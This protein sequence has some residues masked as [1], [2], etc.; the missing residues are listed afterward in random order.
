MTQTATILPFVPRPDPQRIERLHKA[1]LSK[2]LDGSR[3]A[4]EKGINQTHPGST[5]LLQFDYP[6]DFKGFERQQ[7]EEV[8]RSWTDKSEHANSLAFVRYEPDLTGLSW[9]L[10]FAVR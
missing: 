3:I 7:V 8:A 4:I 2:L 9:S 5:F 10:R 1:G 6:L